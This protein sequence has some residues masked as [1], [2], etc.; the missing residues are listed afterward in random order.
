MRKEERKVFILACLFCIGCESQPPM[1]KESPGAMM[2]KS[3]GEAT[4]PTAPAKTP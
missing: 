2:D 1:P 4:G 3:F